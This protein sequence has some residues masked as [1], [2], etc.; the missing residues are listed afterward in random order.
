MNFRQGFHS[1][2]VDYWRY[3]FTTIVIVWSKQQSA[4][5]SFEP[6]P[7]PP[8]IRRGVE[9]QIGRQMKPFIW[10][11]YKVPTQQTS[12]VRADAGK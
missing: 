10:P 2:K 3:V 9:R 4:R 1:L 5:A 8:K 11:S 12:K 6:A 7:W